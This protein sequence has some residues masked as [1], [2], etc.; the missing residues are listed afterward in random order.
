VHAPSYISNVNKHSPRFLV[1]FLAR[2]LTTVCA[3][4]SIHVDFEKKMDAVRFVIE[5]KFC[6]LF[7]V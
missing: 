3:S 6:V 7:S 4:F 5:N 2:P 1:V